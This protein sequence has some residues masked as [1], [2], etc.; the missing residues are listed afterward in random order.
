MDRPTLIAQYLKVCSEMERMGLDPVVG[1]DLLE[2][3][4]DSELAAL[5]KEQVFRLMRFRRLEGEL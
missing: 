4:T 2:I 1:E 5:V 3:L